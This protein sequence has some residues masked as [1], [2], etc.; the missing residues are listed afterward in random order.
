M[1]QP[2]GQPVFIQVEE[3]KSDPWEG[4]F[5]TNEVHEGSQ[6]IQNKMSKWKDVNASYFPAWLEDQGKNI[7]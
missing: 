1:V 2:A 4:L 5:Q 7:Y 6:V 3:A